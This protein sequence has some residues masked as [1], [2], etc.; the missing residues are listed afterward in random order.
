MNIPIRKWQE[1]GETQ[2]KHWTKYIRP[3]RTWFILGPL[4]MIVEVIGEVLMPL[5]LRLVMKRCGV[6]GGP[7]QG[8]PPRNGSGE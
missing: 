4:C 8:I 3:Y 1:S 2:L 5:L 6:Q 7:P